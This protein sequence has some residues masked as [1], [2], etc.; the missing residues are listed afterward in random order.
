ME[1][2][3]Q[4]PLPVAEPVLDLR[5]IKFP[6]KLNKIDALIDQSMLLDVLYVGKYI[7]NNCS[8]NATKLDSIEIMQIGTKPLIKKSEKAKEL[9]SR[10]NDAL[11]KE[12]DNLLD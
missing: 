2:Y 1:Y 8:I 6:R 10:E 4:E 9:E 11:D 7:K 3:N 12:L 5:D